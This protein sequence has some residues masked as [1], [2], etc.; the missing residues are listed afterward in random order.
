LERYVN[1]ATFRYNNRQSSGGERFNTVLSKS[2]VRL[3]FD[4][5][6]NG[7]AKTGTEGRIKT[8]K[9]RKNS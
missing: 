4:T 3:D 5:L 6:V 8:G 2:N 7:K 9:G 1:E